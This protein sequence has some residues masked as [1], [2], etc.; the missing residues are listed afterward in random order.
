MEMLE[1]MER[2]K[3]EIEFG[4]ELE[5]L[6]CPFC[7]KPRS[8]RSDY[9]R[10]SPCGVNWLDGENID[11]NPTIERKQKFMASITAAPKAT[12]S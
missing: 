6:P 2:L 11:K 5:S 10:C 7:G 4:G 3:R 9:V 8:Q 1:L 12:A